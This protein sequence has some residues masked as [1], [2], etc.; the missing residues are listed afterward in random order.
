M[1]R[2]GNRAPRSS[3]RSDDADQLV[4]A[5][6]GLTLSEAENAF[7][8]AIARDGR[9]SREDVPL[10]LEEKRQVIRK[11]GLLEYF[12]DRRLGGRGRP[13]APQGAGSPGAAP[14]SPR[15]RARF[16]LPEPKGLLLLGVQGCGKSLTAQGDRG[17]VGAA[18]A[19]AR[20]GAH[21][22]RAGRL[23][24]GEPAPRHPRRRE[25]RAGG[26]LDRRDRE[27]ALR[28]PVLGCE[29]RR[30]HRP[31]LR[32]RSSPGS[33]RRPRRSSWSR[34]RTGSSSCR[35]SC[36]ARAAS[37]TSS[38]ST[39]PPARSGARSSRSTSRRRGRDP[40]ALRPRPARRAR[41]AGFSG[42][43]LEQAGDLGALRRVRRG[44]GARPGPPRAGPGRGAAALHHHA[45][46][47][48]T[49]LREWARTRTRAAS[50][51]RPP[52]PVP[53]PTRRPAVSRLRRFLHLER[54][55]GRPPGAGRDPATATAGRFEERRGA[56]ARAR[57]APRTLRR[58]TRSL[59]PGAGALDRAR[60]DGRGRAPVHPLHALR[61]GPRRLRDRV[62]GLRREPRH[63]AA[64]RVQ[65]AALGARQEESAREA[66][67]RRG[68]ARARRHA[69][70]A[71][72]AV[73][74][75]APWARPSRARWATASG[76]RLDAAL[77][78]ARLGRLALGACSARLLLPRAS[79]A[80]AGRSPPAP[81]DLASPLRDVPHL[82]PPA[83]EEPPCRTR[84]ETSSR[85]R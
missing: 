8:K 34:P 1:V 81:L 44:D 19:P 42:A 65:R 18:A 45:A 56:P 60:R 73:A 38:S 9:L 21:L 72:L 62:L 22:Q 58:R 43:E 36:C 78:P 11:S 27:G 16:G 12:A 64:A 20:H 67:A 47:R 55:R 61:D 66:A 29:R 70:G 83:P 30:R 68:A 50:P 48:S 33:R 6:L 23:L 7:A 77:G 82:R 53:P 40:A 13:R 57:Q 79:A 25:R 74:R 41:A 63:R 26:A 4:Q 85:R 39:C 49:R 10:V 14:P 37:T 69:R 84:A 75:S 24:G 46:R 59:R 80:D 35:P 15:R 52:E 17:A 71:E 31:R 28:A 2:Q 32:R 5:A 51:A 76:A 54:S 3:S